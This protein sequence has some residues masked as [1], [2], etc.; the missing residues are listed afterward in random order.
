MLEPAG[1]DAASGVLRPRLGVMGV[2]ACGVGAVGRGVAG[3]TVGAPY[4]PVVEARISASDIFDEGFHSGLRGGE[5][6]GT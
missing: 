5:S 1:D 4:P 3:H 6:V 2:V